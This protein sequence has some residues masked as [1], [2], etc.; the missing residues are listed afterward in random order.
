MRKKLII[1]YNIVIYEKW[2]DSTVDLLIK[3][4]MWEFYNCS[5]IAQ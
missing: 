3:A 2:K 1:N 5:R 4:K